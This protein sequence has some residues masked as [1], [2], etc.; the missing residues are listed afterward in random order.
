MAGAVF[1]LH[2]IKKKHQTNQGDYNNPQEFVAPSP[3][4]IAEIRLEDI[5][6]I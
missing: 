1:Y 5:A 4:E 2:F 6:V 3:T